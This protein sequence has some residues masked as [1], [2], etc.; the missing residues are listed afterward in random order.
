MN[1]SLKEI[2]SYADTNSFKIRKKKYQQAIKIYEDALNLK[3]TDFKNVQAYH[4][5]MIVTATKLANLYI[6]TGQNDVANKYVDASKKHRLYLNNASVDS[7]SSGSF[8]SSFSSSSSSSFQ[9][10][11]DP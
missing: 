8:S 7:S 11:S 10:S 4:S 2:S 6:A 1:L 9:V 5:T 3:V